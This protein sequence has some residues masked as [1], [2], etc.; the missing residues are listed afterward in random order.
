MVNYN[1]YSYRIIWSVEDEEFVGLCAEFPSLSHL[2]VDQSAALSGITELVKGVVAEMQSSG[3]K[4]PEPIAERE[5]SGN[6]Q[7]RVPPDLHRKLA[8]RAAE[9]KVSLNRYVS[10]KLA[11]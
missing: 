10:H 5:F 3:E 2:D 8:T 4:V 6:F 11:C 7:V 9:E 1:H